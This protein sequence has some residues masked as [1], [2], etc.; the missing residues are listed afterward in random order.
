[1]WKT[2]RAGQHAGMSFLVVEPT[3]EGQ[4]H[5]GMDGAP[6]IGLSNLGPPSSHTS[7]RARGLAWVTAP[8]PRGCGAPS[9][10]AGLPR[11]AGAEDGREGRRGWGWLGGREVEGM[12]L[13]VPVTGQAAAT[14]WGR[15]AD[16]RRGS[17]DW[18]PR[19]Q[20]VAVGGRAALNRGAVS[21]EGKERPAKRG[22][23]C[24]EGAAHMG[25]RPEEM[26]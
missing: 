22:F 23:K 25:R 5:H 10:P 16:L 11:G 4:S 20:G 8:A 1:M 18:W 19:G 14:K 12:G 13:Q 17:A 3:D 26:Q 24:V 21:Q 2:G 15:R 6:A 9:A 7:A